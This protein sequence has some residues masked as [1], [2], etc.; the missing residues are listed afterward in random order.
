MFFGYENHMEQAILA[1]FFCV[2][3]TL[4]VT[5][6]SFSDINYINVFPSKLMFLYATENNQGEECFGREA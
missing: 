6:E 3:I 1:F 5:T 4:H 2:I